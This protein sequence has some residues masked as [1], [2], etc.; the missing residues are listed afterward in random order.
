MGWTKAQ[1]P[2]NVHRQIRKEIKMRFEFWKK[3]PVNP[4]RTPKEAAIDE[5]TG[6]LRAFPVYDRHEIV[7]GILCRVFPEPLHLHK[8]PQRKQEAA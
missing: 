1:L 7:T 3:K 4:L 2:S 8:N 5:I 6:K